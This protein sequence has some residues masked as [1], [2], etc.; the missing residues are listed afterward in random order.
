MAG[1]AGEEP[2]L[3]AATRRN[4]CSCTVRAVKLAPRERLVIE[5][6]L[7]RDAVLAAI[8]RAVDEANRGAFILGIRHELIGERVRV[9]YWPRLASS[10]A[11]VAFEGDVAARGERTVVSGE[12]RLFP[13]WY[14]T[15][16]GVLLVLAA[17]LPLLNGILEGEPWI[18]LIGAVWLCG[19]GRLAMELVF[20]AYLR[21]I[22]RALRIAASAVST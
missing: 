3:T 1:A 2:A 17:A 6:A 21:R 7:A 16:F 22:T 12:V 13:P 4:D 11:G 8:P 14:A 9:G 18:G 5:S 10:R 19:G 15:L 20:R